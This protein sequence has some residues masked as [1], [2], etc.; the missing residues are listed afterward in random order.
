MQN[1][2]QLVGKQLLGASL[3]GQVLILQFNRKLDEAKRSKPVDKDAT[4]AL[5]VQCPWRLSDGGRIVCGSGNQSITTLVEWIAEGQSVREIDLDGVGGFI[6]EFENRC[7][8]EVFPTISA[9]D[10]S[11]D[12]WKLAG[13]VDA[14]D[15]ELVIGNRGPKSR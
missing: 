12:F 4:F 2:S 13:R 14:T 10:E 8:L 15:G 1:P 11:T 3:A 6:L 9:D 5:H 7:L